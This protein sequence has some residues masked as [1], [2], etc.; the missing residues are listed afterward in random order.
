MGVMA[1]EKSKTTQRT[2]HY[3]WREI[4]KYKWYSLGSF[5]LTPLVVFTRAILSALIFA[6]IIE[7]VSQNL[8][9]EELLSSVAVEAILYLVFYAISKLVLEELRLYF[10]WKMEILAMYDLADLCFKTIS[11]QSMQFHSDRFSGSLVSQTNKFI[12]AFERLFDVIIWDALF[13]VL[14]LS[15]GNKQLG[16]Q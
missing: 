10:C 5:L 16:L 15:C 3:F 9:L 13:F 8:P 2:L 1:K 4:V 7:K 14:S 11:E 12:G 6:D